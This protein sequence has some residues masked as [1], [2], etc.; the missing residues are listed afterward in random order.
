MSTIVLSAKSSGRRTTSRR[1]INI[2]INLTLLGLVLISFVTGWIASFLGLT[3]FGLHKYS[4][5]ALL[6]VASGHVV[7]HWRSLTVQLRNIGTSRYDRRFPARFDR[8]NPGQ[9]DRRMNGA[10]SEAGPVPGG[11]RVGRSP[12]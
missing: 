2:L 1:Y 12:D 10:R 9:V 11:F 7:L 8:R 3:E 5:I 6:L 4:S